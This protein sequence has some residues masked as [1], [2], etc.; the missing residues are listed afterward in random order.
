PYV[1]FF[2]K[3][4]EPGRITANSMYGAKGWTMHHVTDPFGYTAVNAHVQWGMFPMAASWV[5]FPVWRHYEF[6]KDKTYL[7]EKAWPMIREAV[8]FVLDFL[9]ESPEGYLV[10]N[11]SYSPENSFIHK[12]DTLRLSYAPTMD[13]MIIKEIFKYAKEA[14]E[15]LDVDHSLADSIDAVL[16]KLPPIQVGAD[17]TIQEWIEDYKELEPW[18]RHISHLLGLHPGTQITEKDTLLFEA[19]RETIEKRLRY[20]GGHTGWSRAWIINFYARLLDGDEAYYH[21]QKLFQK[22]TLTN[23]FDDHPPFQIDG[24]FGG[25]AGIAEMLLQ[26]HKG[27]IDVLP[28]LP[29]TIREGSIKGIRARGGF[30]LYFSWKEGKLEQI[31][32]L[33]TVGDSCKI[34]YNDNYIEFDT[35]PG[36]VYNLTNSLVTGVNSKMI[37]QPAE[38][39]VFPNP[40]NDDYFNVIFKQGDGR[41]A[42]ELSI[43]DVYGRKIYREDYSGG[44]IHDQIETTGLK[45]HGEILFIRVTGNNISLSKKLI[46]VP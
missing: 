12:N 25:T 27:Y 13:I 36:R 39:K 43:Y 1:N 44:N 26:S 5:C 35:D 2:N 23:L 28:A 42:I 22:S 30:E 10:T 14:I 7:K 3:I 6:F 32:I 41:E 4:R 45:E 29:N 20:G 24:N 18:H 16:G 34:K 11:P 9:V 33:S 15:D 40:V 21:I 8:R 46:L 37:K 19:A 31:E 17:G 38:L